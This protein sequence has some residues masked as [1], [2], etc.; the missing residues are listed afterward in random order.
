MKLAKVKESALSSGTV[1]KTF[2]LLYDLAGS[3]PGMT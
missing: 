2:L 3:P 1:V